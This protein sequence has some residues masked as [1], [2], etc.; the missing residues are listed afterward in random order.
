MSFGRKHGKIRKIRR[1]WHSGSW[2]TW[3]VQFGARKDF[4]SSIY[5]G[6][7]E[8]FLKGGLWGCFSEARI[9]PF[10]WK[11]PVT[12]AVAWEWSGERQ[13]CSTTAPTPG[14]AVGWR[15]T[16]SCQPAAPCSAEEIA[17][18]GPAQWAPC[19]HTGFTSLHI[20]LAV[21]SIREGLYGKTTCNWLKDW[22]YQHLSFLLMSHFNI[23]TQCL[24]SKISILQYPSWKL[25]F[26][27]KFHETACRNNQINLH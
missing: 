17:S 12:E 18:S 10:S 23:S 2:I 26:A 27:K 9:L 16:G 25:I 6:R 8:P 7:K 19:F 1:S 11:H 3:S 20:F 15:H 21:I 13:G 22:C 4:V 24:N 5:Q 14:I